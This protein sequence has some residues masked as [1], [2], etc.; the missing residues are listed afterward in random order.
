MVDP[1]IELCWTAGLGA[2]YHTVYFGD[3]FDDVN[4]ATGGSKQEETTY[5]PR[6][7]ELAKTY[8]WRVDEVDDQN[9]TVKGPL[10]IFTT[11]AFL[12]VDDFESYI[13]DDAAGQAIWQTWMDGFGVA[14]N[15][16]Q[17]GY[18]MPPY[19]EQTIVH[20]G[21]QSMPLLYTIEAGVT[22]SE[23]TLTLATPRDWTQAGVTELP[24][25]FRGAAGNA[26]IP[27]YT[28]I[29]NTAGSPMVVPMAIQVRQRVAFGYSG[30]SHYTALPIRG[31]I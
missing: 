17:V 5:N 20:G 28:S 22:N 26:V 9:N 30:V 6:S 12:L 13:D 8:Y 19:A 29:S 18:L 1:N 3:N 14:D 10:W 21:T 7:L 16:A 25:W 4:N 2:A 27:L 31:S 15:G 24:L 11:G 23:A